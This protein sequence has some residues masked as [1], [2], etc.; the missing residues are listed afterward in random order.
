MVP[1]RLREFTLGRHCAR[2]A[3]QALGV[4]AEA[5]PKAADRSPVWQNGIVGS[6]SHS[7]GHAGAVVAHSEAYAGLGLDIETRTPLSAEV[8]AMICRPN[9]TADPQLLFSLK[10]AVYKCIYPQLQHYVDF[11]EMEI[12]FAANDSYS[13]VAHSDNF[14]TTVVASLQGQY[15]IT[16]ELLM[17]S[18]WL[19]A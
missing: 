8:A 4:N 3:I 14:D 2:Q 5:I 6:I 1:S 16:E 12:I 15:K 7:A 11:Q 13:A 9:E 10:E 18:A 17:S 19:P